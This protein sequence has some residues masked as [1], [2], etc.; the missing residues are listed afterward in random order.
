MRYIFFL[1]LILAGCTWNIWNVSVENTSK[2]RYPKNDF[3]ERNAAASGV[4][5]MF[6]PGTNSVNKIQ[7]MYLKITK[8]ILPGILLC[9]ILLKCR[10]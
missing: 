4:L 8:N 2:K 1:L 6:W 10:T 3:F 5:T 9:D 7:D